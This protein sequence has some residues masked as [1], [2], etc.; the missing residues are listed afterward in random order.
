MNRRL[1]HTFFLLMI[2]APAHDL[3]AADS[4]AYAGSA[5]SSYAG[6]LKM[7]RADLSKPQFKEIE[8]PESFIDP[9]VNYGLKMVLPERV[10]KGLLLK[11]GYDRWK[12]LPTLT[13]EYFL[14]VK[15]TSSRSLFVSQRVG[16][17][18][19]NETLSLGTGLRRMFGTSAVVGVHAF[20]DWV[21]GRRHEEPFLRNAGVGIEVSALPGAFSD[22]SFTANAYFP[23][24]DRITY[25]PLRPAVTRELLPVGFDAMVGF[26]LPAISSY[27]DSRVDFRVNSLRGDQLHMFGYRMGLSVTSRDGL[28]SLGLEHSNDNRLGESYGVEA[29]VNLAFDWSALLKGKSPFSAP[30]RASE[31]RLNR[32]LKPELKSRVARNHNLPVDRTTRELLPPSEP[33]VLPAKASS[34]RKAALP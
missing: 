30:Y 3:Q 14:P 25:S 23:L 6:Y 24:N 32:D 13:A 7:L 28:L 18:S 17:T 31:A 10:Q 20:H 19:E 4:H 5:R 15:E 21:R 26:Q 9:T 12:G 29:R 11:T 8:F 2:L 27:V 1:L 33:D 16:L 34:P 22:L